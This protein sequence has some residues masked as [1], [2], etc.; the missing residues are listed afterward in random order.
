[1]KFF[2]GI[3]I[4]LTQLTI[5]FYVGGALDLLFGFNQTNTGFNTLLLL[6]VLVPLLN[7]FWVIIE[8]KQSVKL[9]RHQQRIASILMPI[10]AILFFIESIAIDL[11]LLSQARM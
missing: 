9:F 10:V 1:M 3:A 8:I 2:R 6:F 7:L 5:L 4:F 11:Y